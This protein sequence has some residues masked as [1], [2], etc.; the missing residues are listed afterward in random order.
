MDNYYAY[1]TVDQGTVP[2]G[3][4][5]RRGGIHVD[6][7]Q[8]V[9]QSPKYEPDHSYLVSDVLPTVFYKQPFETRHLNDEH[10]NFFVEMDGQGY[11]LNAQ[12]ANPYEVNL[13]D[14]YTLHRAD[15]AS[16]DTHRTIV[17]VTFSK[18]RYDRLGEGDNPLI[19]AW[20]RTHRTIS[21]SLKRPELK[22]AK[23]ILGRKILKH[24]WKSKVRKKN[25]ML[26]FTGFPTLY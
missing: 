4:T 7:F 21:E 25:Q 5:Q 24:K 20:E 1:L 19:P 15:A 10:H 3:N 2:A 23:H 14:A 8:G 16:E 26:F 11:E 18:H 17:R 22:V 6:G 9:R 12:R 13:M